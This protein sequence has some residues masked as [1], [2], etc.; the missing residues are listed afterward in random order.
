MT[1]IERFK[2][3]GA[4]GLGGPLYATSKRNPVRSDPTDADD[5]HAA[6]LDS[7]DDEEE[8]APS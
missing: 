2:Y 5:E 8:R 7:D 3:F 4:C 6:D 1:Q